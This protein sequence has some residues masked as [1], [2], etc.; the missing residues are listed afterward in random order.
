MEF[1]RSFS[2]ASLCILVAMIALARSQDSETKPHF[3]YMKRLREHLSDSHLTI[4]DSADRSGSMDGKLVATS[5]ETMS[6][7]GRGMR[8]SFVIYSKL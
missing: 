5:L 3:L 7:S 4:P 8:N 2:T 6:S 1:P